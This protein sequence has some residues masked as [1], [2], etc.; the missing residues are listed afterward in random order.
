[1]PE[2]WGLKLLPK[3]LACKW[4]VPAASSRRSGR[5]EMRIQYRNVPTL[6][7]RY[8]VSAVFRGEDA[9]L[10]AIDRRLTGIE[11]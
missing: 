7:D 1:M 11:S 10:D 9:G 8:A 5:R 6:R 3:L 4:L 2:L